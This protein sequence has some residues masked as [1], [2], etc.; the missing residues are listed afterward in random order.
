MTLIR[1]VICTVL[2]AVIAA[3][4]GIAMGLGIAHA[5]R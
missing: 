1:L 2:A 3:G 4:A 5:F